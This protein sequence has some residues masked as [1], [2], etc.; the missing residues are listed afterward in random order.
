MTVERLRHKATEL[1]DEPLQFTLAILRL[2]S[3][4]PLNTRAAKIRETFGPPDSES[5][6]GD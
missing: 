1:T 2:R 6:K 3:D 4:Y 5:S